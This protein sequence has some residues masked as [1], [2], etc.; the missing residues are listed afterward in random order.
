[1]NLKIILRNLWHSVLREFCS[2]ML[3]STFC[4]N[5]SWKM[6]D[7]DRRTQFHCLFVFMPSIPVQTYIA[8]C[9]KTTG[10]E[11][12]VWAEIH[13]TNIAYCQK[14][15]GSEFIAWVKVHKTLQDLSSWKVLRQWSFLVNFR[16]K[17]VWNF[18]WAI[19]SF[20]SK[21]F[22]DFFCQ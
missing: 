21:C 11:F 12:I 18:W 5:V 8:Y 15:T 3:R 20:Y 6:T 22:Y 9:Q 10:T 2:Y 4:T 1:M 14:T 16:K 19:L 13:Q 17:K 7:Y